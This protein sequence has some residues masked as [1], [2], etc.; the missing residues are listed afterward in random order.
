MNIFCPT[1][2]RRSSP[3]RTFR[4]ALVSAGALVPLCLGLSPEVWS[5]GCV[6]IRGCGSPLLPGMTS[7]DSHN[8]WQASI[9]Y[10]Y[11]YADR[12][13]QGSDELSDMPGMV[14]GQ[15]VINELHSFDLAVSYTFHARLVLTLDV[16]VVYGERTSREEHLG[17]DRI[18]LPQ[19]TTS[20]GGLGDL[21]VTADY[22]LLDP[23]SYSKGN[24]ALGVG[25]KAP[26]GDYD[27]TD[28]FQQPG[29]AV[30]QPVDQAI[31]PGDGGWGIVFQ[32]QGFHRIVERLNVYANGA[33]L[34]NP[35]EE[36]G[37]ARVPVVMGGSPMPTTPDAWN[38]VPD[39][40]LGRAGLDFSIWPKAGLSISLGGRVEGIPVD[41]LAGGDGGFRR[42]GYTVS[43]EPGMNWMYGRHSFALTVPVALERNRQRSETDEAL[44]R[45]MYPGSFA[46]WSLFASYS[47]R[48]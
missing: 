7:L 32:L 35:R 4:P 17:M 18:D 25:F 24:L 41:D 21:R 8:P 30:E 44:G 47:F 22:W 34:M 42:P 27:A 48:F 33:Y 37:V 26:T 9:F 36:N 2:G 19:Y 12:Y 10:R 45:A 40:Y 23:E 43:I 28:T 15:Q 1:R 11:L 38:S 6:P 14:P 39:Q 13:F 16:P 20:A 29:G 46:D 31:Q 3:K 5:Q